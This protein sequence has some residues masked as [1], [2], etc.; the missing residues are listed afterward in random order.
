MV[1]FLLN[2]RGLKSGQTQKS[3]STL[4]FLRVTSAEPQNL[5]AV[6]KKR[7]LFLTNHSNIHDKLTLVVAEGKSDSLDGLV[8]LEDGKVAA[9]CPAELLGLVA[10]HGS[11]TRVGLHL[12]PLATEEVGGLPA[13]GLV[14]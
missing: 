7:Q 2:P 11:D 3:H 8:G 1:I 4:P 13:T 5:G 10:G 6:K 9:A 14:H 12:P